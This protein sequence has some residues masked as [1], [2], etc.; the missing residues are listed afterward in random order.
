MLALSAQQLALAPLVPSY[1]ATAI[2]A[3]I[4]EAYMK[5]KTLSE[6]QCRKLYLCDTHPTPAPCYKA[7]VSDPWATT[8]VRA[9]SNP[10]CWSCSSR[11]AVYVPSRVLDHRSST[12]FASPGPASTS[13]STST[14]QAS[15][16]VISRTKGKAYICTRHSRYACPAYLHIKLHKLTE[17]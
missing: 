13:S 16:R 2:P 12:I 7:V 6:T 5:P 4:S 9:C 8:A 10:S 3:S 15:G 11:L 17:C 14:T 1:T